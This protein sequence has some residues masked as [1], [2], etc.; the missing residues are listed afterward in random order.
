MRLHEMSSKVDKFV[1]VEACETFRGNPKPFYFEKNK[2]LFEKFRDK[3]IHIKITQPFKTDDPWKRERFQRE[4]VLKGLTHAH[5]NDIILLSDLDE[6]VKAERIPEIAQ[7]IGS[8]KAEAVVCNQ[9]MYQGYL[10]RY[11]CNWNGTVC[12]TL[13]NLKKM[14]PTMTR[15]LRN[16][17]PRILRKA[18]ISNV[19]V[20]P[21]AGWHF[22][23]MGGLDRAI[24]KIESI[25]HTEFD[26]P[27]YK[28]KVRL[29][30]MIQAFPKV[31]IDDSFPRFVQENQ[32]KLI[33][34]G[35]IDP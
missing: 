30:Q 14:S 12:T 25:S 31:P 1:I 29:L 21:D 6:I 24:T 33:S 10:N 23:M 26:T 4:Q 15:R 28:D 22:T 9:K 8:K 32:T 34:A 20:V 35:F 18:G 5:G 16:L 27:A 19:T 2:H 13:K 3:I 17:K 11:Q 7:I